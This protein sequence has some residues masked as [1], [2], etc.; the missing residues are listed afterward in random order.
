M[1]HPGARYSRT[2]SLLKSIC[3]L[4]LLIADKCS[5][6]VGKNS[7]IEVSYFAQTQV[8]PAH[9]SFAQR[10]HAPNLGVSFPS[11]FLLHSPS[12]LPAQFV[13]LPKAP[14]LVFTQRNLR[15]LSLHAAVPRIVGS[16]L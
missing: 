14:D 3:S 13:E 15:L 11:R 5:N 2:V 9:I 8:D 6:C 12:I 10:R 7:V 1:A 16:H 4:S